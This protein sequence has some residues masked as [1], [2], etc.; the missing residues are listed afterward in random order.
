MRRGWDGLVGLVALD[1][2]KMGCPAALS[3]SRTKSHIDAEVD[4]MFADAD[5]TDEAEDQLYGPARGDEPP[6]QLR[7]RLARRQRFEAAKAALDQEEANAKAAHEAHLA[8]RAAKEQE[9]G[10]KLRGRKPKPPAAGEDLKANTSDPESRIMKTKDGYIQGYNAQAVV[11]E[12][13]V[14]VGAEV[15]DEQNDAA[16]LHPML[17][18][19]ADAL[20]EAGIDE[21]PDKLLADAGYCSEENL[22]AFGDGDPD[23]YVATRN[24][25]KNPTPRSGRRGPLRKGA[26]RV[27][28]MDRKVSR[29]AGAALYKKRQH[30]VEPV[31]GQ[32]KD[33][34]GARRFMRRGKQAAQSEWKLLM[35]THNLLK[36]YRRAVADPSVAPW[37]TMACTNAA[38]G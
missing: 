38:V 35:G 12:D 8:E 13:Q 24:Q 17:A 34:R 4:K 31:F 18:A 30:M 37:P 21:R 6:A 11:N 29:T 19:T 33:A 22:A 15:T 27:E 1:G 28:K 23:P 32:T 10:K 2:T 25:K 3:T 9:S 36:L 5:A 16:Q 7:G 14:V 20:E 26:T